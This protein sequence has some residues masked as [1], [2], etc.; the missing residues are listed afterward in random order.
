MSEQKFKIGEVAALLQTTIRTIRYYEE[1]RLL[2][3]LRTNKGTRLYTKIHIARLRAILHLVK[4]GFPIENIRLISGARESCET[5]RE[6]S[7]KVVAMLDESVTGIDL[8]IKALETLRGEFESARMLAE[9]CG[10]CANRP[11]SK[12]C[13]ECPVKANRNR[14]ELLTLLWDEEE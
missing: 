2:S 1:E 10:N 4:N 5:G 13:P 7:K 8:Q 12:D 6:S 3:P 11:N 9:M 14:V